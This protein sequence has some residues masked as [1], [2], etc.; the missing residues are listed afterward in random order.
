MKK[1]ES[2]QVLRAVAALFV[3]H[4]HAIST[5]STHGRPRQTLYLNFKHFG[6]S[7]VDIFFAISGFILSSVVL[8]ASTA[9][10]SRSRRALDFLFRRFIRIFPIY[11][12]ISFFFVLEQA[13][14]HHV[15]LDRFLNSYLLL[16]SLSFPI[17]LPLLYVGWT[18]VFEMF[19]YYLIALNLFFGSRRVVERTI[20]TILALLALGSFIGLHR[21]VLI[22]LA[23]PINLEFLF[24]CLIGLAYARFGKRHALGTA[25]LLTGAALLASTLVLGFVPRVD[26]GNAD[27]ILNGTLSWLR[28]AVWG[29]PAAMIT[30]GLVFRFTPIRS[31]F[32]RF[33]VYLGDASYS[34]YLSS[35]IILFFYDHFY[36]P[37]ARFGPDI[38]IFLS[39]LVVVAVGLLCYRFLERPLT[40]FLTA[41]YQRVSLPAE[42]T[43]SLT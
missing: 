13:R 15:T 40:R 21:P 20:L 3:V 9:G 32:G 39:F 4:L 18:L 37:V 34:I 27:W 33:G 26:L 29:V 6:A 35:L 19:F 8:N 2:I 25:L 5:I 23:N 14:L 24:G 28:V 16:P 10:I 12:V 41:R 22:L 31:S 30:A 38:N 17:P 1:N 7:G 11:W 36:A 43:P 42:L